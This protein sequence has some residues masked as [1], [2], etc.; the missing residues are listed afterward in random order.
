MKYIESKPNGDGTFDH[1]EVRAAYQNGGVVETIRGWAWEK[2]RA[3]RFFREFKYR[4][5]VPETYGIHESSSTLREGGPAVAEMLL[6]RIKELEDE[7][8]SLKNTIEY[9]RLISD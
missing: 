2:C 3:P 4:V 6:D 8:N 9:Y 1:T 7:N 5:S